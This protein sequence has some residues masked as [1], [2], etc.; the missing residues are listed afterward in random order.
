MPARP[1]AAS[2]EVEWTSSEWEGI[3]VRVARPA[4]EVNL[5]VPIL[6]IH[7]AFTGWW[8]WQNWLGE[9]ARLGW[10][11][12]ALSLRGHEGSRPLS[13]SQL[14]T[15]RLA[16]YV[17]DVLTVLSRLGASII[18][19]HSLGGIVAQKVAERAGAR[20]L[21][22]VASVG[23]GQLG[24]HD[25]DFPEDE[26]AEFQ[27][28]YASDRARYRI[29]DEVFVDVLARLVPESPRA[30]NDGRGR[31]SIERAAVECPIL[32]VGADL[33]ETKVPAPERI[34]EFYSSTYIVVNGSAHDVM[35]DHKWREAA[36]SIDAWLRDALQLPAGPRA[37]RGGTRPGESS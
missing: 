32:V 6:M 33:D 36:L 3:F 11:S 8:I 35:V 5:K 28:S 10:P 31:T 2:V 9:F 19:G 21:V 13:R 27:E 1:P 23:P 20:A 15:T 17:D 16:D 24:P 18:I 29:P 34:A 37:D 4:P 22:L 14:L 12:Y 26:P 7:G 30:L 25:V